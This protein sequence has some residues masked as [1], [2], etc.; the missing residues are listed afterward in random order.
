VKDEHSRVR[1]WSRGE[2]DEAAKMRLMEGELERLCA[3]RRAASLR[4][5][6]RKRASGMQGKH[7]KNC[8]SQ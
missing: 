5:I 7:G 8:T 3:W 1:T 4:V 2:V 6:G